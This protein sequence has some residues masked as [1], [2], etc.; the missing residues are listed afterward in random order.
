MDE[1]HS[2]ADRYIWLVQEILINS[3]YQDRAMDPW[4]APVFDPRKR[5]SGLD[6]P[7]Q[8]L[9]MIGRVRLKSLRDCCEVVLRRTNPGRFRRDRRLARRCVHH[10]GGRAGSPR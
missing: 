6:W 7:Q 4:S 10:D 5:D 2:V 9:T 1:L 8:A 3:I